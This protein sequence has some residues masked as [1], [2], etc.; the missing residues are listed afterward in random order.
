M[1]LVHALVVGGSGM[2]AGVS[3]ELCRRGFVPSVVARRASRLAALAR[4]VSGLGRIH[5]LAVDYHSTDDLASALRSAELELG[6]FALAVV[7]IHSTALLQLRLS[8][9]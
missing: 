3:L 7:W 5:P 1:P 4:R 6:T 8:P 9:G 2:L